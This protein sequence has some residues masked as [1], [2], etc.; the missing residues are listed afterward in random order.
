MSTR[1][2]KLQVNQSGSWRN[3]LEFDADRATEV[4]DAAAMLSRAAGG[5]QL[6]VVDHHGA[7]RYLNASGVFRPAKGT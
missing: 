7:R 4:E 1:I 6:A 3:V 2:W 5:L